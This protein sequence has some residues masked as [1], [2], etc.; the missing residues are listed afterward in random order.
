MMVHLVFGDETHVEKPVF[1]VHIFHTDFSKLSAIYFFVFIIVVFSKFVLVGLVYLWIFDFF[2]LEICVVLEADWS[3][4]FQIWNRQVRCF[5]HQ[6]GEQFGAKFLCGQITEIADNA[7][8]LV[9]A[10]TSWLVKICLSWEGIEECIVELI[11]FDEEL[12][13]ELFAFGKALEFL[14][15]IA[16]L[17]FIEASVEVS[18]PPP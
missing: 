9:L 5:P 16:K 7:D 8:E 3:E 6:H 15:E 11:C 17:T 1:V 13:L 4:F 12:S 14:L 18:G 2:V 10:D